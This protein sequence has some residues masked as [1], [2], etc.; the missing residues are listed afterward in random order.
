MVEGLESLTHLCELHIEHQRLNPGCELRFASDTLQALQVCAGVCTFFVPLCI[1]GLITP[2]QGTVQVLNVAGD[3]LT[4][5]SD[6][7]W[8]K[9][10]TQL[11]VSGNMLRDMEGWRE[12]LQTNVG[13]VKLSVVGN[14]LAENPK[15]QD[16]VSVVLFISSWARPSYRVSILCS[17][18]QCRHQWRYLM[19]AISPLFSASFWP[20]GMT[21][22]HATEKGG[23]CKRIL[24]RSLA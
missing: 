12:L 9:A 1:D 7:G 11:N 13:L 6:V 21:T 19:A 10:L 15:H 23:R 16:N 2:I 4:T 3:G 20:T 8:F 18:F 24:R 17:L 14:P 5:V 22:G